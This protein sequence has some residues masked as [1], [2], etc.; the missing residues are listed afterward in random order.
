M[1]AKQPD[2]KMPLQPPQTPV[3]LSVKNLGKGLHLRPNGIGA[4][5]IY[6]TH[7]FGPQSS[8]EHDS[9]TCD[10]YIYD[11]RSGSLGKV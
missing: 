9:H 1:N 7:T 10:L 8:H 5:P 3:T 2:L 4:T 11:I 6:A